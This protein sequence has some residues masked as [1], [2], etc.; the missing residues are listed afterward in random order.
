MGC[1][2]TMTVRVCMCNVVGLYGRGERE[3]IERKF[4]GWGFGGFFRE[5]KGESL[6]EKE[7]ICGLELK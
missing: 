3:S 2:Y 7:R 4:W 1:I 5:K 6:R